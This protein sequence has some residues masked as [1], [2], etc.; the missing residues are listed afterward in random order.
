M[1]FVRIIE[2]AGGGVKHFLLDPPFRL[3]SDGK[4]MHLHY[5]CDRRMQFTVLLVALTA[6]HASAD[7]I[8]SVVNDCTMPSVRPAAAKRKFVSQVVDQEIQTIA[9]KLQDPALAT[10]FSNCLPNTVMLSCVANAQGF[11]VSTAGYHSLQARCH[12]GT[13]GLIHHYRSAPLTQNS[14][15]KRHK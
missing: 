9:A 8:P 3:P 11:S 6:I 1:S 10:L 5:Y 15:H 2:H 7:Q 12:A 13:R 4:R 14:T